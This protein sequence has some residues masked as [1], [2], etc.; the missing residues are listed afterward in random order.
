MFLNIIKT[1]NVA[2]LA[3]Q[4]PTTV[5][6]KAGVTLQIGRAAPRHIDYASCEPALCTATVQMDD[7]FAQEMASAPSAL[8]VWTGLG[9][10]E[11]RVEYALQEARNTIAFL[12][13]R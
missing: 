1:G 3:V 7:A 11:I 12:A 10:G 2:T 13:T 8:A 4:T 5:D 6:I 9:I